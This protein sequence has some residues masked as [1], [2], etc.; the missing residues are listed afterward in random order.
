MSDEPEAAMIF[1]AGFGT[2]MGAL[3]RDIPKPMIPLAGRPMI[4]HTVELLR[5]AGIQRIFANTH[6]LA[7][8]IEPHLASLDVLALR[9]EPDILETG[10]GLKA[11]LPHLGKG[12][13]LTLN[14]DAA[15]AGPN[16]IRTL[17]N[18]W[19]PSM[20]ALLLLVP[21]TAAV[22]SRREGDFSL[23]KGK[24]SRRGDYL[25]TGAQ[26]LRTNELVRIQDRAFSLNRYWDLLLENGP[27]HGVVYSGCWCDVGNPVG[28]L[29]AEKMLAGV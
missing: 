24:I 22:T 12:P 26:I 23:R 8:R 1:A 7:D 3:T 29:A 16:P 14:P 4:D 2:R 20:C 27:I 6:H 19:R 11:A 9:E 25:Y 13:V 21:L 5:S 17:L 10:G 18:A 15:W 28:L